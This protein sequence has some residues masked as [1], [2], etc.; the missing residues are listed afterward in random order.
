MTWRARAHAPPP[1]QMWRHRLPSVDAPLR[2]RRTYVLD[3]TVPG[4]L[5]FRFVHGRQT[6]S[7]GYKVAASGDVLPQIAQIVRSTRGIEV[8]PV[9]VHPKRLKRGITMGTPEAPRGSAKIHCPKCQAT[10][11]RTMLRS[12]P[13]VY[14]RCS[15]CGSMWSILDRREAQSRR[16]RADGLRWIDRWSSSD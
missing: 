15:I 13:I 9:P 8:E 5:P 1:C 7:P 10:E 12:A 11:A 4:P 6:P 2:R 3:Q 14:V 16:R